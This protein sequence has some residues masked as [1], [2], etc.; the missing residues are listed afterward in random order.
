VTFSSVEGNEWP[1]WA[2]AKN[3]P[4]GSTDFS[5][6]SGC[7]LLETSSESHWTIAPIL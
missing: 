1:E 4:T 3:A 2:S 7:A 5:K 6:Y